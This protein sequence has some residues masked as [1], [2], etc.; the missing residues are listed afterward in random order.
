MKIGFA[1]IYSPRPI[2]HFIAFL[3]HLARDGGAS[4]FS[5]TCDGAVGT[6]YNHLFRIRNRHLECAMCKVGGL[7]SFPV[8]NIS[9][10]DKADVRFLSHDRARQL[11]Y[12][13]AVTLSRVEAPEDFRGPQVTNYQDLLAGGIKAAYSSARRWINDKELDAVVVYNGRMDVTAAL[14]AACKD[15]GKRLLTV[16]RAG[17]VGHGIWLM[18]DYNCLS[19]RPLKQ[20]M[21]ASASSPLSPRQVKRAA[22]FLAMRLQRKSDLEW[23]VYNKSALQTEWPLQHSQR[24]VLILPSS[25]NELEGNAEWDSPL[26]DLGQVLTRL[27]EDSIIRPCDCVVRGHPI[28]AE[29]VGSVPFSPANQWWQNYSTRN[30]LFYIPSES[31][32]STQDLIREADLILMNGSSA[33]LEAGAYG[34][35]VLCF[36]HSHYEEAGFV[37]MIRDESEWHKVNALECHDA[38]EIIRQTLRYIYWVGWRYPQFVD[39]VRGV[40]PVKYNFRPGAEPQRLL[41]LLESGEVQM[42]DA[43]YGVDEGAEDECIED[44]VSGNI[45]CYTSVS[46]TTHEGENVI[47]RRVHLRAIDAFRELFLKGDS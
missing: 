44:F 45:E 33:A 34:K 40:T 7:R 46:E 10:I 13:S 32:S 14:A 47:Q 39:Y 1:S 6:C 8:A 24:R 9:S 25:R 21:K 11:A 28:W 42:D 38:K 35:Q 31:K 2:V 26:T 41:D 43:T 17:L 36:G 30:S 27:F 15:E 3:E 18:P 23:R 22:A 37:N 19:L 20:T 12:S 5:L 16:E 29:R 4:T